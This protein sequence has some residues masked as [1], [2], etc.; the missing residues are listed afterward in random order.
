MHKHEY[1]QYLDV[2]ASGIAR[3]IIPIGTIKI[4]NMDNVEPTNEGAEEYELDF[5]MHGF[6]EI[7]QRSSNGCIKAN[8]LTCQRMGRANL[9]QSSQCNHFNL[10]A[11]LQVSAE[12]FS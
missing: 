11:H 2:R 8:C 6:F 1:Q 5:F 4:E 9:L 3:P 10:L 12:L 7:C